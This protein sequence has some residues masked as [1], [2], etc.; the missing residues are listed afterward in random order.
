MANPLTGDF[1]AVLQVSGTTINR[2]LA[3]MHQNGGDNP[4]LPSFPHCVGLRIGD[5]NPIDGMRGSMWAQV[6]V[7]QIGL[8]H[9]ADDR[10]HLEVSIRARYKPDPGTTH[11]PEFIHGTV[12]ADYRL[13]SVDPSCLGW[14]AKASEYLWVRVIGDTV[15]F[16][17]TAF[18]SVDAFSVL[19]PPTDPALID[20]RITR[21]IRVLLQTQFEATPHKVSRR[22]RRGSMRSLNVGINRSVVVVP[23]ALSGDPLGRLDSVTQELLDGSDFGVA[24]SAG[25]FLS[26]VQPIL[27]DLKA[28]FRQ[29]LHFHHRDYVDLGAA[30]DVDVV[31]IDITWSVTL[32]SAT[33]SWTGGV[34]PL[35]GVSGGILT[36]K[37]AGQARTQKAIFNLD[38]DVTQLLLVTF[39]ASG[40]R[41]EVAPV[42][43]ASVNVTGPLAGIA[44]PS[45]KPEISKQVGAQ[46]KAAVSQLGDLLNLASRKEEM[47]QQLRTLDD[48]A[49]AWFE[50]AVFSP[51]GAIVRG[52]IALSP[53][54]KPMQ[55]VA[56]T[57]AEDGF[58]AYDSWIP[59]GRID[60]FDWSWSWFNNADKPGNLT[61]ADRFLLRRPSGHLRTKFGLAID[62]RQPLPG[63]DGSGTVCLDM[64][65]V[66]VHPVTGA[67]VPVSTGR[68]C[69]RFGIDLRMPR[70]DGRVFVREVAP[71]PGPR[72][73][74]GPVAEVALH[75]VG[76]DRSGGTAANALVMYVGDEWNRDNANA[77]RNALATARR[78]DAGL[79]VLVLFRDGA[80]A[81]APRDLQTELAQFAADLEAPMLVNEDV[82]GTWT[83]ALSL[84][85]G[86]RD[87]QWRLVSPTGGVTWAR[88]GA[89]PSDELS[90]A[91][92]VYLFPSSP[93]TIQ[94]VQD[95]LAP[96]TRLT[97]AVLRGSVIDFNRYLD[98]E[99][100]CPPPPWGPRLGESMTAVFVQKGSSA[101]EA[102]LRRIREEGADR[103]G[104]IVVVVDGAESL[105]L[106]PLNVPQDDRFIVVPDPRGTLANN[107]GI[108][109]WPTSLDIN[110]QGIVTGVEVGAG[111][112]VSPAPPKDTL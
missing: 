81:R 6:S 78:I 44:G 4:Q 79:V 16:S 59:G 5:P 15:S 68:R 65:G 29:T 97:P 101:S 71:A 43:S 88:A 47:I 1:E 92:D 50:E 38:F 83:S 99:R 110:E 40:E 13:E 34:F 62:L 53:R 82:R 60:A 48:L 42:G 35:V 75:D 41:F 90:R 74:I 91:L 10:F 105:D 25:A 22:F 46:V 23:L 3:S 106:E 17:G 18:D 112:A 51:D 103:E 107:F 61:D 84:D 102:V 63:L 19:Q 21:L 109:A 86:T 45:A 27:D 2:L 20:A 9:G 89:I 95:G 57:A 70:S 14:H 66:Q 85:P 54:R 76:G 80:L 33:A 26:K 87:V 69:K 93:P 28:Q 56:R 7:P 108:R 52:R 73:P 31:T 58:S 55:S 8:I 100:P 30:G 32:T 96:G 98:V 94:H 12:R 72:D 36:L 49:N 64:R 24:L 111:R 37:I 11:L 104:T 67:L 39:N 77:L